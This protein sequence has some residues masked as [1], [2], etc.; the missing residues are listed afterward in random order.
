M[1]ANPIRRKTLHVATRYLLLTAGCALLAF[2]S[3]AFISPLGLVTGGVLS[4]GII[5]QHF[6]QLA[7][8]DFYVVDIVTW[9][10]Q[11]IMLGVSFL[12]LG[13]KYTI[14]SLFAT[15]LYPALFTLMTRVTIFQGYSLGNYVCRL[16]DPTDFGQLTLA[17]LAG[18][19]LIGSGVAICYHAG[20]STGGFD[21]LSTLIAKITPIKEGI[22]T[23]AIDATLVVAGLISIRDVRLA[24]VGVLGAFACALAVQIVYVNAGSFI[25]ADIISEKYEEIQD[26]V[27]KTMDHATTVISVTGGYTG[28]DKKILRVAFSARELYSFRAFIGSVDPSAFVT[29]TKASMINGEGFD[30]LV[31]EK[32]ANSDQKDGDLHG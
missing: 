9:A 8:S 19:A 27:H 31:R 20:G 1:E 29:F 3:A 10:I 15:L 17:T 24:L 30:P 26:Y 18:G 14:R 7:G 16:F 13:K 4:I 2:G 5:I 25:I 22:S 12:F 23:F 32:K 6:I 21:V 11:L 28:E